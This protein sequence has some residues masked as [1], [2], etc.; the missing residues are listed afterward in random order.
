MLLFGSQQR[1]MRESRAK[2]HTDSQLR[3]PSSMLVR[4]LHP[5]PNMYVQLKVNEL[6]DIY[7]RLSS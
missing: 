5:E 7:R 4:S 2:E 6:I 3:V 1:K